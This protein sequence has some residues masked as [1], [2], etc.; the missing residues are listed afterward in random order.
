[1]RKCWF[2]ETN[3]EH[4]PSAIKFD[5]HRIMRQEDHYTF[6]PLGMTSKISYKQCAV[7]VPRCKNCAKEDKQSNLVS[8]F[9]ITPMTFLAA[10]GTGYILNDR[11]NVDDF[12]AI[13]LGLISLIVY[14]I[15]FLAIY[16]VFY[17][18][19]LKLGIIS[20]GTTNRI[21]SRHIC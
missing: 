3:N 21:D 18:G 17:S 5:L 6:V 12:W 4:Y 14:F 15:L 10:I 7:L 1:M 8:G 19:L 20:K 2:C 16:L 9:F 11:Y 13:I